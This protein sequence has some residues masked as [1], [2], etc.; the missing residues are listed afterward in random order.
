MTMGLAL[1]PHFRV[2]ERPQI[3]ADD[4]ALQMW[5]ER[6]EHVVYVAAGLVL[7][8]VTMVFAA[9]DGRHNA[10][11]R[12]CFAVSAILVAFAAGVGT[13]VGAWR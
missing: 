5:F 11:A 8:G 1:Y 12:A 2:T 4:F 7:A 13:T 3:L 9:R 10:R 6:K